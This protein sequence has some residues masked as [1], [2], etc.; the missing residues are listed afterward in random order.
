MNNDKCINN[1]HL[2]KSY[3]VPLN[4]G[5]TI[6]I[7]GFGTW[8]LK[9]DDAYRTTITAIEAGYRHFDTAY[10]YDNEIPIGDAIRKLISEEKIKRSELFITSKLWNTCFRPDLVRNA[11]HQT[12][13]NLQMNYIDLYLIHTPCAFR[14]LTGYIYPR[15]NDKT[16]QFS[17]VDYIPT[18]YEMKKIYYEGLARNVGVSNFNIDQMERVI[19]TGFIP[20][21]LQIECHPFFTQH[22]LRR[23][24]QNHGIH[25]TAHSP[26]GTPNRLIGF[27]GLPKLLDNE[28]INDIAAS[29]GKTAAQIVVRYQ[30]QKGNS[31]IPK[32]MRDDRIRSNIE[33]FDF[34][35]NENEMWLL[36]NLGYTR[37]CCPLLE[38]V[39]SFF[40]LSLNTINIIQLKNHHFS[41]IFTSLIFFVQV[42]GP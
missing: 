2:S 38:L 6:P 16:L 35:L 22:E 25:V 36:D 32:S 10:S 9:G 27:S 8:S 11:I 15:N 40:I 19:K 41:S 42:H 34:L 26:L 33:V 14:E 12:L 7:I 30:I 39:H 20:A 18:W 21:V 1:E 31:A 3:R 5:D 37:R 29:Y 24:C 23:Y 4:T 17:D 13:N 28:I